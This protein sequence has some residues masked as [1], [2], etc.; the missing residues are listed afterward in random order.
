MT[1]R[2]VALSVALTAALCAGPAPAQTPPPAAA[3]APRIEWQRTLEDA[4]AVQQTTGLPLLLV[5][6]M[7]GETFNDRF[8]GATYHE[9]AFVESTRGYVCVVASPDRHNERDYDALGR[10]V[11]CPRFP[12]LV[13]SE[14]QNIEPELFRRWFDG[15][16]NA[17]RHLSVGLDGKVM[18]DRYLDASMQTAI[19]AV[20]K[21]RGTP[22]PGVLAPTQDIAELLKRRDNGARGTLERLYREGDKAQ[23]QRI[24]R[25]AAAAGN[26]PVD[27]LRMAL[28]DED[29]DVFALVA[30]ALAKAAGKDALIDL[31]D[32]LSKVD[33]KEAIGVLL[34]RVREL[35]ADDAAA[36]RLLSHFD[37]Q[38]QPLLPLPMPWSNPWADADRKSVV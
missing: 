6:N 3:A 25:A 36:K 37:W 18:F 1:A 8:A 14:H 5:V 32:A 10:R 12:G 15:K 27:L 22:K 34:G 26:Q 23:R 30:P 33:D 20:A 16:R 38:G 4:L 9:A 28:R 24:L 17:P 29:P 7:D 35:A 21:H 11:E 13:C 31:E 2:T 19:D